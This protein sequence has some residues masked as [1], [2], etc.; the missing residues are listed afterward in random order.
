[1]MNNLKE[2]FNILPFEHEL[3][4]KFI[5]QLIV[6][7]KNLLS[8]IYWAGG[9]I[10][11][12]YFIRAMLIESSSNILLSRAI[13]FIFWSGLVYKTLYAKKPILFDHSFIIYAAGGI[14]FSAIFY[15]IIE[16]NSLHLI[17]SVLLF[18][19][20]L[21]LCQLRAK[22]MAWVAIIAVVVPT[23]VLYFDQGLS[24]AEISDIFIISIWAVCAYVGAIIFEGINRKIFSFSQALQQSRDREAEANQAKS[25]FIALMS[26]EIRTPLTSIIGYSELA[27]NSRDDKA[28]SAKALNTIH[29]NSRHLLTLINDLLDISKVE[30][31]NLTLE[32]FSMPLLTIVEDACAIVKGNAINKSVVLNVKYQWPL[33]DAVFIDPT[34]LRQILINLLGNAIKFTLE[35]N[36][37]LIISYQYPKLTFEIKDTGIGMTKSQQQNLFKKFSQADSS[38]TRK[39]GG[40]GLGLYLSKSI[41]QLMG[42]D[43]VVRSELGVGS[44]FCVTILAQPD[45]V[46]YINELPQIKQKAQIFQ[47][48]KRL[49][50][51][52][53]LV[54]D[55]EDNRSFLGALL[56]SFGLNVDYSE[57]GEQAVEKALH[58]DFDLIL[59]DIQMP[60]MNGIE[61]MEILKSCGCGIPIIALT[62][63]AMDN[64]IAAYLEAGFDSCLRKPIET[65]IFYRTLSEFLTENEA[66]T[67][68]ESDEIDLSIL[69][70]SYQN[71]LL[72][73]STTLK[74][75]QKSEDWLTLSAVCHQIKGAAANFGFK[76]I[77][78]YAAIVE[79]AAIVWDKET[80]DDNL[81]LMYLQIN[82]LT[83]R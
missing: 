7:S 14:F 5:A 58:D 65:T 17:S 46:K 81:Q 45:G 2:T 72:E 21:L 42:G 39:F 3:E 69:R 38:T 78:D 9:V 56:T 27:L 80:S 36:V 49:V 70:E 61:A 18:L 13:Y 66:K 79:S 63:N 52:I 19:I 28:M 76:K 53:L 6:R 16:N 71:T 74:N 33:P 67:I 25:N 30:S 26:H 31:E 44:C 48:K 34:R 73:A 83:N 4:K 32:L 82:K 20:G 75:A 54:D 62:A 29:S 50:G 10:A 22:V 8:F 51:Y 1:M 40:S 64:E 35:G 77:G 57:N 60:I 11:L 37:T 24:Q 23:L 41:A 47:N 55:Y 68:D 12:F 15:G 43:I 59:M